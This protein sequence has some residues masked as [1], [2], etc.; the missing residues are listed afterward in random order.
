MSVH[1]RI[2]A[3]ITRPGSLV[4]LLDAS[5]INWREIELQKKQFPWASSHFAV[6]A[7]I[8]GERIWISQFE[9]GQPF[10]FQSQHKEFANSEVDARVRRLSE[11][12]DG[13]DWEA[14]REAKLRIEQI[15]AQVVATDQARVSPKV[16][17]E[18]SP[19][20]STRRDARAL[21]E[22]MRQLSERE[23]VDSAS[24]VDGALRPRDNRARTSGPAK[25]IGAVDGI[26]MRRQD[27][28]K[29][30][31]SEALAAMDAA[32]AASGA[33][34]AAEGSSADDPKIGVS[35]DALAGLLQQNDMRTRLNDAL[36]AIERQFGLYLHA[37]TV[38]DDQTIEIVLRD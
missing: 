17:A 12:G 32:R 11:V 9:K 21:A 18:E 8:G 28:L 29:K 20:E 24:R 15:K 14:I 19:V 27:A 13:A 5:G 36:G 1:T 2:R 33:D 6:E 10:V 37:E 16:T 30:A 7:I 38:L 3:K 23:S 25:A 4:A 22:Q 26:E 35:A 31:A 34:R